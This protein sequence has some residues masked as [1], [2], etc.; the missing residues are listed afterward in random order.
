MYT[1]MSLF[2]NLEDGAF[3]AAQAPDSERGGR[4]G[5]RAEP[6]GG[7]AGDGQPARAER[8]RQRQDCAAGAAFPPESQAQRVYC[9]TRWL[10]VPARCSVVC[11]SGHA[12]PVQMA[13][14][15][16]CPS[17]AGTP[18]CYEPYN[19]RSLH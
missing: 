17:S 3:A 8:R 7:G 9:V 10:Q 12:A 14:L 1:D 4:G 11:F 19:A 15:L 6:A 13:T 16:F 2:A 5:G 18:S